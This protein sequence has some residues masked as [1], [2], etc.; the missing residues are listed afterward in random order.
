MELAAPA[1]DV[2]QSSDGVAILVGVRLSNPAGED[3]RSFCQ[4]ENAIFDF[5]FEI[6]KAAK[7]RV[8]VPSLA[9]RDASD[10]VVYCRDALQRGMGITDAVAPGQ[11]IK[12]R[13]T[14][15]LDLR[16]GEYAFTVGLYSVEAGLYAAYQ[17]REIPHIQFHPHVRVHASAKVSQFSVDL[18]QHGQLRHY[19]VADLP[20]QMAVAVIGVRERE[21]RPNSGGDRFGE[22]DTRL[23]TVVHVTHWKAG[24]QWIRKILDSLAPG[25]VIEPRAD[26]SQFL[27]RPVVAGSVYPTLYVTRNEYE[28]VR[29]P[30]DVRRL[31]V[32]R[33]LRDTLV[34]AYFSLR[35]SH[36][37]N[38]PEIAGYRNRLSERGIEEGMLLLMDEWLTQCARIQASWIEADEPVIR[39]SDL[40]QRDMDLLIPVLRDQ[41]GFDAPEETIKQAIMQAR[42]EKQ[43]G[44][45]RRGEEDPSA[46]QRKGVSGDW[47]NY[48]TDRLKRAFKIRYGGL[49]VETRFERNLNW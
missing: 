46:H 23:P 26:N 41:L 49:L 33:D 27:V 42:F 2:A 13:Q 18:D 32:I 16:P 34:S 7:G 14:V 37:E 19:G 15:T 3:S 22:P 29:L 43:S 5:E 12:C 48:F 11:R 38:R 40:L 35:Y 28:R 45:R 25:R 47:R 8:M 4:G 44:G 24:S 1:S 39:Y 9:V 20:A 17:R 36:A 30:G 21:F 6:L 31:T 10:C